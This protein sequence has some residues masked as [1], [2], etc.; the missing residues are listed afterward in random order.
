MTTLVSAVASHSPRRGQRGVGDLANQPRA[1]AKFPKRCDQSSARPAPPFRTIAVR[2]LVGLSWSRVKRKATSDLRGQRSSRV[3]NA[4]GR[5]RQADR[6]SGSPSLEPARYVIEP[7]QPEGA[8]LFSVRMGARSYAVLSFPRPADTP[9][10]LSPAE[11]DVLE[12]LLV[13]GSNREIARV[14]GTSERTVANQVASL[15]AKL[16]VKSRSELVARASWFG[17]MGPRAA[18]KPGGGK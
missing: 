9:V 11:Q 7:T 13:G 2:R 8:D 12:L 10:S 14:R 6:R 18:D 3:G 16:G 17:P 5:R 4:I 1:T 15:F